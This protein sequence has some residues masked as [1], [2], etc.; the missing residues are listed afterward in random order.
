MIMDAPDDRWSQ[1]VPHPPPATTGHP[2]PVIMFYV[3]ANVERGETWRPVSN[4]TQRTM[5]RP[6]TEGQLL[7]L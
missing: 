5:E 2:Q 6:R 3:I 4:L 1:A 7:L